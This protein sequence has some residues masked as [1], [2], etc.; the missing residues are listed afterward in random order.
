MTDF[1]Q[2]LSGLLRHAQPDIFRA[3]PAI[4]SIG[5]VIGSVAQVPTIAGNPVALLI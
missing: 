2:F 5:T 1:L 3:V 4:S